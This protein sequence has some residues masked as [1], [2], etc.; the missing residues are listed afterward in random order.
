MKIVALGDSVTLSYGPKRSPWILHS[1]PKILERVLSSNLEERVIIINSG[2]GGDTTRGALNRLDRDV[3]QHEPDYLL[4]MF[5]LNDALNVYRSITAEEY[6]NNLRIIVELA[7]NR[8]IKVVLLTP[9]PVTERFIRYREGKSLERL[10]IFVE[11]V[12][13][14]AREL[15]VPLIDVFQ[16]FLD[17]ENYIE[18]LYDGVH[19]DYIGQ[20]MLGSY[21]AYSLLSFSGKSMVRMNLEK[22]ITVWADGNYN[23]FTDMIYWRGEYYITFRQGSAHFIPDVADGKIMVIKS[24][25]LEKWERIALLEVE[26]WDARDPKFLVLND[27][28]FIYTQSWSPIKRIHETFVFYTDDGNKWYGPYDCGE[29]VFW[30][31]RVYE[32]KAYVIAYHPVESGKWRRDE[33]GERQIDLLV[34]SDGLHWEKVTTIYTGEYVNETDIL[35]IGNEAI[36]LARIEKDPRKPLLLKSRHPFREWSINRLNTVLQGPLLMEYRGKIFAIGRMYTGRGGKVFLPD[37]ARTGI[38]LL[39]ENKLKLL[40]ELP[41]AGDTSYPGVVKLKNGKI[42]ISYYSSHER[43]LY[44]NNLVNRYRRFTSDYKPNIYLAILSIEF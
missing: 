34:S 25:D 28:L 18:T 7:N 24:K 39:E 4:V 10:K 35:F 38:F 6:E 8:N 21:L 3:F 37:H 31:P 14:I 17:N 15:N 12:R 41:S 1:W 16:L 26:G 13:K 42:A 23:A 9:N 43:Y 30:R 5:G 20:C 32:G 44:E 36:A 19:P 22:L 11:R 29:Q 2:V 33:E 40:M 27:R